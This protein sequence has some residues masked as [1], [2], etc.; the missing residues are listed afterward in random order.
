MQLNSLFTTLFVALTLAACTHHPHATEEGHLHE[1]SLLFTAY[2]GDYELYAEADPF[3][4]GE[5]S[6]L[7]VHFTHLDSFKPLQEGSVV[8][9]LHQEEGEKISG[10]AELVS[11]GIYTLSLEPTMTGTGSLLFDIHSSDGIS[12]IA[13]HDITLYDHEHEAHMAAEEGADGGGNL[14]HFTK[15]QSWKIN[16]ATEEVKKE[17]FGETIRT[18]AQVEPSQGDEQVVVAKAGGIVLFEGR[19]ILP[20]IDV[21]SGQNLF[22]MVGGGVADNN[23][24]VR[25]AEAVAEYDKARREYERKRALAEDHI[26][27]ESDLLEAETTFKN[28]EAVYLNLRKSIS[29]GGKQLIRAPMNGFVKQLFV[30]NGEYARAGEPL[31]VVSGN[32][33]LYLKAELQPKY[34]PHLDRI[35]T[36]HIKMMQSGR[37]YRLED[38]NGRVVSYGRSTD[39][40][41]PLIPL[42]FQVE[43]SVELL[44]GSF[45][46]L[47][48]K[49]QGSDEA[50]TVPVGSLVEEMGSYFL[51]VQVTPELFEKRA[52]VIGKSDGL[53]R[54]IIEGLSAGERIVSKGAMM[55]KLSQ[56]TGQLDAHGHGH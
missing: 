12:Q 41:N 48:I 8:V 7:L 24:E 3:V 26:V 28:S 38:L 55:V 46:E 31:L 22:S 43:N 29:A 47:Y 10:R 25:Y 11:D 52:V 15:E 51:Y 18:V 1:E 9:T 42:L 13:L 27:S 19:D 32:R 45:V 2:N 33:D 21:R 23:M 37:T 17:P 54:E 35:S 30:R 49:L 4:V 34:Y 5:Q 20:G 16:F 14:L 44:P 6:H 53:R 50:I 36:A 40:N 39:L 56:A